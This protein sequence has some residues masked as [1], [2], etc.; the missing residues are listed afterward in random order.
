[1]VASGELVLNISKEEPSIAQIRQ[2]LLAVRGI[3]PWTVN[4]ALLRGYGWLDGSLH[5]DA[6]VR[7]GL[8]MLLDHDGVMDENQTQKWLEGFAPWR[9]LV[10]AH[11]WELVANGG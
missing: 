5:G 11:L 10:A 4:Y 1:M 2:Q 9:A 3:G 6:A 8:Q 7:R